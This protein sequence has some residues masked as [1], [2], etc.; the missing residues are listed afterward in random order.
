MRCARPSVER[1]WDWPEFAG[2]Q[3]LATLLDR[4]R[5]EPDDRVPE[6]EAEL[7]DSISSRTGARP[8]SV[9]RYEVLRTAASRPA[10]LT[11]RES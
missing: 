2:V 5:G 9:G 1:H 3:G 8:V 7:N 6:S 10:E 4:E 11:G